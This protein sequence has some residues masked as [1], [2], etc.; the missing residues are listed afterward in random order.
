[1][2]RGLRFALITGVANGAFCSLLWGHGVGP[3]VI[4]VIMVAIGVLSTVV[5]LKIDGAL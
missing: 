4:I 1:M 3:A 5:A 2:R